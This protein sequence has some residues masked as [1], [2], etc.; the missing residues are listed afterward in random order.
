MRC[1]SADHATLATK[2]VELT[3]LMRRLEAP[4]FDNRAVIAGLLVRLRHLAL[5]VDVTG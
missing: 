3:S 1:D 5:I 4:P 2:Q